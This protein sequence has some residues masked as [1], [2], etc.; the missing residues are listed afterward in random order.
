MPPPKELDSELW[1][2]LREDLKSVPAVRSLA[3]FL[4]KYVLEHRAVL[5]GRAA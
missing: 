2:I 3:D 5:T 1:L 4:T